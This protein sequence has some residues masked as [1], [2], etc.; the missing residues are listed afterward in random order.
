MLDSV[1]FAGGN[2]MESEGHVQALLTFLRSVKWCKVERK[3]STIVV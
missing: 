3:E 1:N 2:V